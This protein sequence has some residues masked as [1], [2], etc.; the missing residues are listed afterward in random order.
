MERQSPLLSRVL[1]QL[2]EKVKLHL[3][4]KLAQKLAE[5]LFKEL[6]CESTYLSLG[7]KD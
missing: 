5:L 4:S 3:K 7:V 1:G 2:V 6:R